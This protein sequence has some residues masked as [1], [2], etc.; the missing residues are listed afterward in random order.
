MASTRTHHPLST[1]DTH[2]ILVDFIP[3]IHRYFPGRLGMTIAPGKQNYGM[4]FNWK[5]DLAQDL[6]RLR[7][8]YHTD[9]LVTLIEKPELTLLK[10]PS[11]FEDI[12]AVGME[13]RWFPIRDFGTPTSM[14]GL[15]ELVE[16]IFFQALA[17]GKTVVV[18]CKAGLGRS[19]LVVAAC[20]VALGYEPD[21]AF[22]RVRAARPGS[23]ETTEQEDY[24]KQFAMAWVARDRS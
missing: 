17:E 18:H 4:Q 20:L 19:G 8:H 1:S 12:A 15:M 10:I 9:L 3:D 6:E 21:A 16:D 23:V 2:P 13:S 14:A 11:L 5:R 24:V 7:N 22:A